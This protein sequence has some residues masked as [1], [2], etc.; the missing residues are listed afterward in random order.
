MLL[1]KSPTSPYGRLAHAALVEAGYD[2]LKLEIVDPWSDPKELTEVHPARRVPVLVTD[3]GHAISEALLIVQYAKENTKSDPQYFATGD[4]ELEALSLAASV[5]D[6]SV[7]IIISR[8]ASTGNPADPSFDKTEMGQRRFQAIDDL[9]MALEKIAQSNA[10]VLT[11]RF[12]GIA[13]V[14]ALNYTQ[15]RFADAAWHARVPALNTLSEQLTQRPS[16]ASTVFQ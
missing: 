16:L 1:I 7:N 15:F 14:N 2:D 10:A 6:L 9:L 4:P 5:V 3:A 12:V 8:K 11:E 13:V